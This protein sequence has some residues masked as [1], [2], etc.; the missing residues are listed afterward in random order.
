VEVSIDNFGVVCC[1]EEYS[2][3]TPGVERGE[4]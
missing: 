2:M 4:T 3:V 1:T